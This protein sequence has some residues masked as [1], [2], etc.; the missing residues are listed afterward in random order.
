[1]PETSP[2]EILNSWKRFGS[3]KFQYFTKKF[4]K[5]MN[6]LILQ[7]LEFREKIFLIKNFDII[8]FTKAIT[9]IQIEGRGSGLP[10]PVYGSARI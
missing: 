4:F 5:E 2:F 3:D 6:P 8:K 7:F 1:L 10:N 9:K